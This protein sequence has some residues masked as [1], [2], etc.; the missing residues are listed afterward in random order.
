[1][2]TKISAPIQRITPVHSRISI[3]VGLSGKI[4]HHYSQKTRKKQKSDLFLSVILLILVV[5][6][7]FHNLI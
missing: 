1:M 3:V 6:N 2:L 4:Y 5:K 7:N